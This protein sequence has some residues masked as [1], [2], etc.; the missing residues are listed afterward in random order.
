MP[1]VVAPY[2]Q[3]AA[4]VKKD[5]TIE[6]SKGV[7]DVKRTD[8]GRYTITL[9]ED[10]DVRMCVPVATLNRS[11]DWH[12]EIYVSVP[13][14]ADTDHTIQVLTGVNGTATDEPFHVVVP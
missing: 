3:A 14:S 7:T 13:A 2:A 8:K 4:V 12:G 10:I 6:R 5:G 11:A 1:Q 9:S